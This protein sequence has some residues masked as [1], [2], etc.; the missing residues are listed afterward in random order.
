MCTV[1]AQ[2]EHAIFVIHW[3]VTKNSIKDSKIRVMTLQNTIKGKK[4]SD[5]F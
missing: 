2:C 4:V 5:K 3:Y 1:A